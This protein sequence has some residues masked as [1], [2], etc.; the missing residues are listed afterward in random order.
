MLDESVLQAAEPPALQAAV[1]SGRSFDFVRLHQMT[2]PIVTRSHA[3]ACLSLFP[4][5]ITPGRS[6]NG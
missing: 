3:V 2:T 1:C 6:W 4:A 5:L